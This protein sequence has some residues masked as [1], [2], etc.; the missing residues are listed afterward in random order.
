M[1]SQPSYL[2]SPTAAAGSSGSSIFRSPQGSNNGSASNSLDGASNPE[3]LA[4]AQAATAAAAAGEARATQ[5]AAQAHIPTGLMRALQHVRSFCTSHSS[6]TSSRSLSA[7][8][9]PTGSQIAA[10]SSIFSS[11]GGAVAAAGAAGT[12]PLSAAG[13]GGGSGA[14]ASGRGAGGEQGEDLGWLLPVEAVSGVLDMEEQ[15]QLSERGGGVVSKAHCGVFPK[16]DG[17]GG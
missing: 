13:G 8:S 17:G 12:K 3:A 10:S 5:V 14:A 1:S 9:S 7:I 15:R 2:S 16:A 4:A 11:A 6:N